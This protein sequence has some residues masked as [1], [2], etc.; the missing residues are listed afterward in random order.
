MSVIIKKD[1]IVVSMTTKNKAPTEIVCLKEKCGHRW[2]Y[3]GQDKIAR[4][5]KC[6]SAR[7]SFNRER[8]GAFT[9]WW[10]KRYAKKTTEAQMAD[11]G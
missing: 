11:V 2:I 1:Q 3:K 5:P 8:F 4:C 6:H 10:E 9:P 7:N